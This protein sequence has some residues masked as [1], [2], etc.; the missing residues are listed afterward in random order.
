MR[1]LLCSILPL[2]QRQF[3]ISGSIASV[4]AFL[5][6]S[7]ALWALGNQLL[8]LTWWAYLM[9]SL[10][11]VR[12]HQPNAQTCA[13]LHFFIRGMEI[14]RGQVGAF[15]IRVQSVGGA[16]WPEGCQV[17]RCSSEQHT[18]REELTSE[19]SKILAE[20]KFSSRDGERLRGRLQLFFERSMRRSLRDLGKHISSAKKV[21]SEGAVGALKL[22]SAA[23]AADKPG[24]VSSCLADRI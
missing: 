18:H 24:G 9:I 22:L 14:V 7:L 2:K 17:G 16:S 3:S 11:L 21:L 15:L 20:G 8:K 19:I 5:R 1:S 12:L 10:S 4:T 13:F 6:V 23:L